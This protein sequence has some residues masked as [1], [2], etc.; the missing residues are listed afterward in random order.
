[1]NLET[2]STWIFLYNDGLTHCHCDFKCNKMPKQTIITTLVISVLWRERQQRCHS[3]FSP[4]FSLNNL[5][6]MFCLPNIDKLTSWQI[7]NPIQAMN[8]QENDLNVLISPTDPGEKNRFL[9]PN[10]DLV[11]WACC[12]HW[13]LSNPKVN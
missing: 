5:F 8:R 1:M 10:Q 2:V 4:W 7:L 11:G 3:G 12:T 6:C 13:Y 9:Q